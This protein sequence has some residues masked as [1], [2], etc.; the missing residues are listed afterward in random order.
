MALGVQHS[1]RIAAVHDLER[2][3]DCRYI[4]CL[5]AGES[6]D[7]DVE[8]EYLEHLVRDVSIGIN[9]VVFNLENLAASCGATF[10]C[11][12]K[13]D[14][15]LFYG[16]C[17]PST[18]SD[19]DVDHQEGWAMCDLGHYPLAQGVGARY[20]RRHLLFVRE[21]GSRDSSASPP[22]LPRVVSSP[23]SSAGILTESWEMSTQMSS[24]PLSRSSHWGRGVIYPVGT[25]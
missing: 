17:G 15:P 4:E 7:V 23:T 1:L 25:L 21:S 10:T 5:R 12:P 11:P 18:S 19:T 8:L 14:S 2:I 24:P 13:P 9:Q 16:I 3:R 20:I 22:L 6:P